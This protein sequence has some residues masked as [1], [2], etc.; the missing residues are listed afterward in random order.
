MLLT[1]LVIGDDHLRSARR[2][3]VDLFDKCQQNSNNVN[4]LGWAAWKIN[5]FLRGI[6]TFYPIIQFRTYF[7]LSGITSRYATLH[8]VTLRY[9]ASRHVTL[10]CITSRY[11][12]LHYVMLRYTASCHVTLHCIKRSRHVMTAYHTTHT[13]GDMLAITIF[14]NA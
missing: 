5:H 2:D 9:T 7:G 1:S 8:H 12:T 14:P 10:H 11:A 6:G 4:K 3:A 13:A